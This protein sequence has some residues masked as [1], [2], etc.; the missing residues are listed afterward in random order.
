MVITR[1]VHFTSC[2]T[3]SAQG[4]GG[5]CSTGTSP[6]IL[7]VILT[8]SN[9]EPMLGNNPLAIE[10][11]AAKDRKSFM[12]DITMSTV[13]FSKMEIQKMKGHNLPSNKWSVDPHGCP[14]TD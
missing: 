4:M 2:C 12:L 1:K 13:A 7:Y 8:W 3:A 9:G 11:P 10:A 5:I 6:I 14:T